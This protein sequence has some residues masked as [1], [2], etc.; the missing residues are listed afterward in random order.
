MRT[1]VLAFVC[2]AT[3]PATAQK[4]ARAP[5]PEAPPR[6]Q[7]MEFGEGDTV[8]ADVNLPQGEV[9]GGRKGV[10]FESMI[11]YRTTFVPEMIRDSYRL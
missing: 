2:L 6:A 1:L 8:E 3:V 7:K 5:R 11:R 10:G 4:R 9:V